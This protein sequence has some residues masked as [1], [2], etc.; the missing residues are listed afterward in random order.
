MLE[1]RFL[2]KHAADFANAIRHGLCRIFCLVLV[3]ASSGFSAEKGGTLI[4]VASLDSGVLSIIDPGTRTVIKTISAGT[5]PRSIVVA[6]DRRTCYVAD[7]AAGAVVVV[8]SERGA[9]VATIAVGSNPR[10][11]ALSPDNARLYVAN[12]GSGTVSV[13]DTARN[14]VTDTWRVGSN[15]ADI[16]QNKTRRPV[17]EMHSFLPG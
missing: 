13:I 9:A 12:S 15:P 16:L 10:R 6:L 11:L 17:P 1:R 3:L 4:Y 8:D 14:V 2:M 5:N 7:E